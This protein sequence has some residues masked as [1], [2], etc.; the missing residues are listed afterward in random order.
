MPKRPPEPAAGPPRRQRL[1]PV[2]RLGQHLLLDP[3]V[4]E[5][6]MDAAA[7][8]LELHD[9]DFT[10]FDALNIAMARRRGLRFIFAF[11]QA[12][13]ILGFPSVPETG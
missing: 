3:F 4:I 13:R 10:F 12:F 2:K 1:R 9:P 7:V 5:Q 8:I 6:I 11:D